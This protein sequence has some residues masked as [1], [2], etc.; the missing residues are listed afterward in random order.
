MKQ[1]VQVNV[2][3]VQVQVQFGQYDTH[4]LQLYIPAHYPDLLFHCPKRCAEPGENR[5]L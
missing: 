3:H 5:C 4:T 1:S 2:V